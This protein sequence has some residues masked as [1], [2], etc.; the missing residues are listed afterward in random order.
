[1]KTR[2]V[3]SGLVALALPVVAANAPVPTT[4][5]SQDAL[6][7]PAHLDPNYRPLAQSDALSDESERLEALY[8][9]PVH[10]QVRIERRVVIRISPAARAPRSN[11]MAE[12]SQPVQRQRYEERKMDDCVEVEGIAGVRPGSGNR[13]VL[14]LEDQRMISAHLDKSCR[15]RD[16]YS[17]F[18]IERNEDG[19]LC[20]ARDMLQSR[21]GASCELTRMRE[22]VPVQ[23]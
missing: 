3:L 23:I 17:G 8:S 21:S 11:L 10:R 4:M 5:A 14:Y 12:Q 19:M 15:A 13:L 18:Y 2:F 20:V 9:A 16:F 22:L 1:M 6:D 7:A